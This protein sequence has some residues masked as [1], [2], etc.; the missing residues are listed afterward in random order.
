[1]QELMSLLQ[2]LMLSEV[3]WETPAMVEA[4]G[5]EEEVYVM[6][7]LIRYSIYHCWIFKTWQRKFCV[8]LHVGLSHFRDNAISTF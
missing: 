8:F 3:L 6:L 2:Q 7:S 4:V 5:E 1:M